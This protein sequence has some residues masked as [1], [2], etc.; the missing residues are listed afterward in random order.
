MWQRKDVEIGCG[1]VVGRSW[2]PLWLVEG[3]AAADLTV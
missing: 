3:Q 2:Y 1:D